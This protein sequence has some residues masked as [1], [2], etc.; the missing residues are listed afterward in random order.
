MRRVARVGGRGPLLHPNTHK[1]ACHTHHTG[2]KSA[3][4]DSC[5]CRHGEVIRKRRRQRGVWLTVQLCWT[6]E[7]EWLREE[8]RSTQRPIT[9]STSWLL[10]Q[11]INTNGLNTSSSNGC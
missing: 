9:T 4:M 3:V 5:K 10:Q 7:G 2:A 6:R 11:H 1:S 8:A